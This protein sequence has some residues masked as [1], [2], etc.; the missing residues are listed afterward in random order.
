MMVTLDVAHLMTLMTVRAR[1]GGGDGSRHRSEAG[2]RESD[3]LEST[4][5]HPPCWEAD[6]YLSVMNG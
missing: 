1:G 5:D 3:E 2:D 6:H 4:H